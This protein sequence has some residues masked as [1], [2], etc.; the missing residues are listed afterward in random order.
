LVI[1][2]FKKRSHKII[3]YKWEGNVGTIT[4][5]STLTRNLWNILEDDKVIPSINSE[6]HRILTAVFRKVAE[7]RSSVY[8]EKKLK[9]GS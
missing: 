3:H 4:D 5:Y 6:D 9:Y 8:Q 7:Q 1:T 2:R